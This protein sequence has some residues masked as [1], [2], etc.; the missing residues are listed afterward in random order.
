[1]FCPSEKWCESQNEERGGGEGEG[2]GRKKL[3]DK[4]LDFE[5]CPLD[6]SRP[7]AHAKMSCCHQPSELLRTCQNIFE[8]T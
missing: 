3:A 1:V 8:S 2:E 7:S 4:S 5:N 6:L